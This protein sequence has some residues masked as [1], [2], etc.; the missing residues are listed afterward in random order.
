M[1]IRDSAGARHITVQASQGQGGVH[2]AVSDDGQGFDPQA[3][4]HG[5]GL[6]GMRRRAEEMGASLHLQSQPGQGSRV[7]LVFPLKD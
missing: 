7:E 3:T 1:C 6:P 2:I 5:R 4:E